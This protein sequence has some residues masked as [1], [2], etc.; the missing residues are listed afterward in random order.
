MKLAITLT[1]AIAWHMNVCAADALP[2]AL[3]G[4]WSTSTAPAHDLDEHNDIQLEADGFGIAIGSS[5]AAQVAGGTGG[6]G[7]TA[8]VILGFPFRATLDG[9]K[10]TLRAYWPGKIDEAQ[11]A[12]MTIVCRYDMAA[13]VLTCTL[14]N[15][16]TAVMRQRPDMVNAESAKM[17]AAVRAQFSA[18]APAN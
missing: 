4:A 3:I 14:P 2:D 11:A 18:P 13:P 16:V 9:D 10:L 8:R 17:I 5:K 15:G 12:H 7:Q 6:A 1:L